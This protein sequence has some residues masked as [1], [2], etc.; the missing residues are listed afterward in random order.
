MK[1]SKIVIG[2]RVLVQTSEFQKEIANIKAILDKD[3]VLIRLTDGRIIGIEP[4]FILKSF[5]Q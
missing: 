5:G 2:D 3:K 1:I 4:K